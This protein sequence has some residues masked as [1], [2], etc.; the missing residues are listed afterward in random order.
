MFIYAVTFMEKECLPNIGTF[1][2][3]GDSFSDGGKALGLAE[4]EFACVAKEKFSSNNNPTPVMVIL[5][6]SL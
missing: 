6:L 4:Y 3:L 1:N 5:S 2:N